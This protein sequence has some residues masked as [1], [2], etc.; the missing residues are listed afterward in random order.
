[1]NSVQ[2]CIHSEISSNTAWYRT[3]RSRWLLLLPILLLMLVA[4]DGGGDLPGVSGEAVSAAEAASE[5]AADDAE[6]ELADPGAAEV[7]PQMEPLTLAEG[8]K[9]RVVATTSLI[10]DVVRRIGGDAVELTM[11]MPIGVDPH[12]YTATPEDLRTLNDAHLILINGLGLEESLMPA[13]TA[14]ENPVPVVSVNAGIAPLIYNEPPAEA[15]GEESETVEAGG[16]NAEG[17]DPHTWLSVANVLIWV[18]NIAA[19]L[20]MLD[21]TNVDSYFTNAGTYRDELTALN[22]ELIAQ[23]NALPEERRKLVTDHQE[24]GYFAEDYGFE[25]V[26]VVLPTVSTLSSPSAQ[27]LAA[28]QDLIVTNGIE[29]IFVGESADSSVVEQLA[30]DLEIEIVPLY[31][32][33]L[34]EADGPAPDYPTLMRQ[35]VNTVVATLAE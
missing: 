35:V 5:E 22:D 7:L 1:M 29:A 12:S 10:A 16:E 2:T 33:S 19:M 23:I 9:L 28:L 21:A 6:P 3:I 13:L 25:V 31:T 30:N 34:S 26:G 15:E 24:F 27:E 20:A 14:L 17:T 32:S 4:C 8:E 11:L 18:D